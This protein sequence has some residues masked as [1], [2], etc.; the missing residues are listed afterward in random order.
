MCSNGL[1]WRRK[2]QRSLK[3]FQAKIAALADT[4][5]CRPKQKRTYW[6]VKCHTTVISWN[7]ENVWTY[8]RWFMT[9]S[10]PVWTQ[11][12][13][14]IVRRRK[15]EDLER[16]KWCQ[17]V[18]EFYFSICESLKFLDLKC[19]VCTENIWQKTLPSTMDST[20]IITIYHRQH[21]GHYHLPWTVNWSLPSTM[22]S[23]MVINDC[24]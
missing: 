5:M 8:F 21:N 3:D 15:V 22:D 14:F 7:H 6:F 20:V 24:V 11:D 1:R 18:T 9:F 17:R 10:E 16:G 2:N 12:E 4:S 23:T 13:F 19:H